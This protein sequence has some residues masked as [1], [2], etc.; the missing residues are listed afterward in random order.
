LSLWAIALSTGTNSFLLGYLA[1]GHQELSII[2]I[3][4]AIGVALILV[5]MYPISQIFQMDEDRNRG[6]HTFAVA[7]GMSG[8]RWFYL[9]TY[10]VGMVGIS[11][12]LSTIYYWLGIV[13]AGA[14]LLGGAY[15]GYTLWNL[16]GRDSEY[17][18]V[19]RIKYLSSL[20]FNVFIFT[21]MIGLHIS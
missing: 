20:L 21:T 11:Y 7:Y 13:F 18:N 8:V 19:M 2:A 10:L 3:V 12:G 17:H 1:T 6:D 9:I 14:A 15:T 4:T 5:S 16:T